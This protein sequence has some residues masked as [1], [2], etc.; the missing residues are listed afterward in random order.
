MS[1]ISNPS[2]PQSDRKTRIIFGCGYVGQRVAEL[3]RQEGQR[4]LAVT[5]SNQRAKELEKLGVEPIV[6]DWLESPSILPRLDSHGSPL[7]LA[8]VLVAVT[9]AAPS[10][11]LGL[12]HAAAW[13]NPQ[14]SSHHP[15][16]IYLSTTG[17]FAT[18]AT[19]EASAR[20]VDENSSV[21]PTRAGSANALQAEQWIEHS[22]FEHVILR[23]AG[24]YGPG[25]IPNIQPIRDGQP[26]Q[27]DPDSYLNLI[28]VDDLAQVIASVSQGPLRHSLYCVSDGN[29]AK[30]RD[31]YAF[32]AQKL[33]L[34][35]PQYSECSPLENIGRRG[36]ANKQ[37]SNRRLMEDYSIRLEYPDYRSGLSSLIEEM[38]Q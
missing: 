11:A 16:W 36:Q 32:I 9:H 35:V 18:P 6:W 15:R 2:N 20:W 27:V 3:W 38:S 14:G 19:A 8:T 30:R 7:P 5:R 21:G 4:V 31:Y 13:I 28:H 33:N 10:H 25:R 22:G 23:P 34:P 37:V 12:S 1:Q 17:V 29:S 26:L 24:I